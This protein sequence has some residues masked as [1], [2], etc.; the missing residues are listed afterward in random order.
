MCKKFRKTLEVEE[1]STLQ[2][3]NDKPGYLELLPDLE[4]LLLPERPLLPLRVRLFELRP[5]EEEVLD[6]RFLE[7]EEF[8]P[9]ELLLL[10]PSDELLDEPPL[11]EDERPLEEDEPPLDDEPRPF[12]DDPSEFDRPPE[13]EALPPLALILRRCSLLMEPNPRREVPLPV[14]RRDD[15]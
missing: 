5:F 8:L 12:L 10:R 2:R 3:F 4:L 7:E 1:Y 15:L 9:E 13:C 6:E 11:E 14:R